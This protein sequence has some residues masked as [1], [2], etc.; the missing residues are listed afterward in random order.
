MHCLNSL[1]SRKQNKYLELFAISCKISDVLGRKTD[2][3]TQKHILMKGKTMTFKRIN[4][5]TICCI[6]TEDDMMEYGVELEDFIMNKDKVQDVLH[7]IVE[8]AVE[9]LDLDMQKGGML[10]LQIMPL[11]DNSIS[12]M[13][14]EKGQINMM[15]MIN[16]LKKALGN[17]DDLKKLQQTAND[18]EI[19]DVTNVSKSKKVLENKQNRE[20]K[21]EQKATKTDKKSKNNKLEKREKEEEE[22]KLRIYSFQSLFDAA[23]FCSYVPTKTKVVSQLYKDSKSD[24]YY[25]VFTKSKLSKKEFA[26]VCSKAVEFGKYISDDPVRAAY[27]EEHFEHIVKEKAVRELRK[28]A[29]V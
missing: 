23:E 26:R 24:I 5:D 18:T 14:S 9:E 10:S 13:F 11:P 21:S 16:Q 17:I 2:I 22:S 8:R 6:L 19:A 27:M 28:F 4:Q 3:V 29:K 15:E 20:F 25:L 7:N 12:I 1:R